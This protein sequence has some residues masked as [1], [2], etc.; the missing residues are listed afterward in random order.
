[1]YYNLP[2]LYNIRQ[3]KSNYNKYTIE[4]DSVIESRTLS[5]SDIFFNIL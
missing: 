2:I 1:M 4:Y 5:T 3:L